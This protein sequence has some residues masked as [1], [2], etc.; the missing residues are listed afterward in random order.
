[1][2]ATA[3]QA[4]PEAVKYFQDSVY[5]S[6]SD[7]EKQAFSE[8]PEEKIHQ[9]IQSCW[10]NEQAKKQGKAGRKDQA[11]STRRSPATPAA[12]A[13]A[14]KAE[15]IGKALGGVVPGIAR[16]AWACALPTIELGGDAVVGTGKLVISA[17]GGGQG[18]TRCT[19]GAGAVALHGLL[20]ASFAYGTVQWASFIS[21]VSVGPLASLALAMGSIA[22]PLGLGGSILA[23]ALL[24]IGTQQVQSWFLRRDRKAIRLAEYQE[25]APG[26][27]IDAG[28]TAT[29]I[30]AAK[31][32]D[33]NGAGMQ[34]RRTIGAVAVATWIAEGWVQGRALEW[35]TP[36]LTISNAG[37]LAV[38][39]F[40]AFS[41][42]LLIKIIEMH[43]D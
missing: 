6:L 36:V 4:S 26:G 39:A 37:T 18:L 24:S 29:D 13:A 34:S 21:S 42:E 22:Q 27:R 43:R 40:A 3:T 2:A 8:L 23:G 15:T 19:K 1:M 7:E 17:T 30:A 16:F 12:A 32:A 5:P 14:N 10:T 38:V 33:Y 31:A 11:G 20:V 28:N 35:V 9:Y 41:T 25:V